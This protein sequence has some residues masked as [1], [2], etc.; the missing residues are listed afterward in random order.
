MTRFFL[1]S[2]DRLEDRCAPAVDLLVSPIIVEI[3]PPAPDDAAETP[4]YVDVA[5][6]PAPDMMTV[7]IDLTE[8]E[9]PLVYQFTVDTE[10]IVQVTPDNDI[11][12]NFIPAEEPVVADVAPVEEPVADFAPVEEPVADVAPVEEPVVDVAP[13]E[14]PVVDVAPV[15]EPV[16]DVA[17]VEEP[18]VD[19]DGVADPF[20]FV[21]DPPL[22]DPSAPTQPEPTPTTEDTG[23]LIPFDFLPL[24][25]PIVAPFWF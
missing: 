24:I 16:V 6:E 22:I 3:V 9:A 21:I 2:V 1:P 4:S 13:V 25:P 19:N 11:S 7:V 8:G 14:E 10:I 5:S 20:Y 15:E 12:V 18:V 23:P 17:P